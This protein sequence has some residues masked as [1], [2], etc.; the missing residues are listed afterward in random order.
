MSEPIIKIR[1]LK[2]SYDGKNLVL[3][4]IN[5]DIDAGQII[6][7]IGP[8]GA[9]KT[10]TVKIL[11][12]MMPD[13]D[14]SVTVMG[15]DISADA[16]AL[17]SRIGYVPENAAMY[18]MLTPMEYLLFIGRFYE[19]E[20]GTIEKRAE[21]MLQTFGMCDNRT[22]RMI[23]FSKGMRQK[24]LICAGMIHNP[25]IIF[26][27]EPLSGLDA[28]TGIIIKEILSKLAEAGKTIFYCSHIMDVVERVSHRIVVIDKGNI[29]AD[30]PF[31]Q[32]QQEAGK[33]HSLEKIFTQLT[34]SHEY[35]AAADQFIDALEETKC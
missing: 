22:Q 13:F 10:T 26:L 14:G 35:A 12:G 27:D 32:L 33:G 1:D 8:N 23:T 30:G 18:E 16:V 24:V 7:Y 11:T 25:E 3:Q 6:G 4:G 15:K 31:E 21:T 9:G 5:L 17:K 29:V 20:T 34:G 28:N 19:L 2:K